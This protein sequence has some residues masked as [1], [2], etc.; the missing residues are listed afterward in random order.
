MMC[1][2]IIIGIDN[3][4]QKGLNKDFVLNMEDVVTPAVP[5]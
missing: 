1:A 4:R 3:Q 2:H 5:K